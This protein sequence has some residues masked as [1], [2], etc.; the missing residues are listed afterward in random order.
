MKRGEVWL[1]RIDEDAPVVV[2]SVQ[3]DGIRAIRVVPPA[4]QLIEDVIRELPLDDSA[5]LT[6]AG[7]VRIAIPRLG[8][9]PCQWL[10]TLSKSDLVQ[11]LGELSLDKLAELDALLQLAAL[12]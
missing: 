11:R 6:S 9:I 2:L 5:G 7:V 8:F 12:D 4:D 1:A 10:V 3:D